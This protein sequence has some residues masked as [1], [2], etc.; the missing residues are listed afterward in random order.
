MPFLD[1]IG[2][3]DECGDTAF[4]GDDEK[5]YCFRHSSLLNGV[6]QEKVQEVADEIGGLD[7]V[8][9]T[10]L[11]P[12]G[13][14]GAT[15]PQDEIPW[16]VHEVADDLDYRVSERQLMQDGQFVLEPK[17]ANVPYE[18]VEEFVD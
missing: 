10:E 13:F 17:E 2:E 16:Q 12:M 4:F 15:T 11:Q 7:G 14:V 18:E 8:S 9:E 6:R 5:I 3:C 1:P